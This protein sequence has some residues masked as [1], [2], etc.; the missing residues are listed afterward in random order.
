[1]NKLYSIGD[2]IEIIVPAFKAGDKYVEEQ[3]IIATIID[4]SNDIFTVDVNYL[5]PDSV[6]GCEES[7]EIEPDSIVKSQVWI[8]IND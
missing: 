3:K 5:I 6:G 4:S 1:M 7:N 2:D 8:E